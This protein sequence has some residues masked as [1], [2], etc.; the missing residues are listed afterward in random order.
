M[1]HTVP[2]VF[3]SFYSIML[4][5]TLVWNHVPCI[6]IPLVT[7]TLYTDLC[8]SFLHLKPSL[9]KKAKKPIARQK[10][11]KEYAYRM[12]VRQ[13]KN[14]KKD[15][16]Y[17]A[18]NKMVTEKIIAPLFISMPFIYFIIFLLP[19]GCLLSVGHGHNV[20]HYLAREW[21]W[22]P[23]ALNQMVKSPRLCHNHL[24]Y[25]VKNIFHHYHTTDD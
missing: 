8:S 2:T 3:L 1:S 7:R 19:L 17:L 18:L 10:M 23:Q 9:F 13:R 25:V 11:L 5:C 16:P 14:R 12:Y 15:F 4:I 21:N 22:H 20:L 6:N 24:K